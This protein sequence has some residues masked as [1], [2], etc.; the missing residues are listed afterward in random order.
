MQ[1]GFEIL[2]L[3]SLAPWRGPIPDQARLVP[4]PNTH[5][6]GSGPG[7]GWQQ[8]TEPTQT[9]VCP[10]S[11]TQLPQLLLGSAHM[12]LVPRQDF[13]P[14]CRELDLG[15]SGRESLSCRL[16][17]RVRLS[18]ATYDLTELHQNKGPKRIAL[19][20]RVGMKVQDQGLKP[21]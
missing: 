21:T 19:P 4:G 3:D 1:K 8:R 13:C 20:P 6:H 9:A 2:I 7:A 10:G 11:P 12:L 16:G 14:P 17:L 18:A 5:P 15:A